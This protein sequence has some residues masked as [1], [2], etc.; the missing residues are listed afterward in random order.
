MKPTLINTERQSG[1][2][3]VQPLPLTNSLADQFTSSNFKLHLK[4]ALA[5][6]ANELLQQ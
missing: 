6:V 3:A 2:V 5:Y 1:Q 4:A